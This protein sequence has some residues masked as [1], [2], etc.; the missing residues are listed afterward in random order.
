[1]QRITDTASF[2]SAASC[3]R[4]IAFQ[5]VCVSFVYEAVR[6]LWFPV[7][8]QLCNTKHLPVW[9]IY[10]V[11]YFTYVPLSM[12]LLVWVSQVIL[13]FI[14]NESIMLIFKSFC[15]RDNKRPHKVVEVSLGEGNQEDNTGSTWVGGSVRYRL[16]GFVWWGASS[17]TSSISAWKQSISRLFWGLA[18][19]C[20]YC[21]LQRRAE[22]R[23]LHRL[24]DVVVLQTVQ[25]TSLI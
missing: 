8:A 4:F 10:L 19:M 22:A 25:L 9:L 16:H 14:Q 5:R 20:C 11:H 13:P 23:E 15:C 1:M 7:L 24:Q 12:F 3:Y 18:V 21:S 17:P 2:H 6:W